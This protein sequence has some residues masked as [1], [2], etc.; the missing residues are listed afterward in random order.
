MFNFFK[1]KTPVIAV[2][3][4]VQGKRL[5]IEKSKDPMFAQRLLG[6]GFVVDP[7]EAVF[8]SPVTG[9]LTILH[10]ALHTYG[11]T[12]PDGLEVLVHIGLHT[13]MLRGMGFVSRKEIGDE[14]K[15]G[16]P[17]LDA[18]IELIRA[19]G[20]SIET[21]VVLTNI[22]QYEILSVNLEGELDQPVMTLRRIAPLD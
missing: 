13:V 2:Y 22:D 14:V 12:T 10:E 19:M 16:E 1:K 5:P 8:R 6:D 20:I 15:A 3:S 7:V 4:P 21:P 9:K 18:D 11:V 17:I